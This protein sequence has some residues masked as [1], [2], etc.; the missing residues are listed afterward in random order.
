ME[1]D[2]TWGGCGVEISEELILHEESRAAE[3]TIPP[4][5]RVTAGRMLL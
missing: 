3:H 5:S 4:T 2:R 1:E